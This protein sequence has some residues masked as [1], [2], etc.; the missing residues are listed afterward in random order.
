MK[1]LSPRNLI[2][3]AQVSLLLLFSCCGRGQTQYSGDGAHT[4]GQSN[5]DTGRAVPD[6]VCKLLSGNWGVFETPQG[7]KKEMCRDLPCGYRGPIKLSCDGGNVSGSVLLSVD[8]KSGKDY[9]APVTA[10]W[11]DG[12]LTLRHTNSLKCLVTHT[13]SFEGPDLVGEYTKENC[14]EKDARGDVLVRKN[15]FRP[16]N[17]NH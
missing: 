14:G 1:L 17:E 15:P 4:G 16:F 6:D 3:L 11:K 5:E 12:K 7:V 9:R 2:L 10:T 8:S 13:V